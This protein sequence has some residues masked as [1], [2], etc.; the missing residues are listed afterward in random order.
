MKMQQA[1]QQMQ[2][3]SSSQIVTATALNSR[4]VPMSHGGPMAVG[5]TPPYGAPPV[6]IVFLSPRYDAWVC[7]F[8]DQAAKDKAIQSMSAMSSAQIVSASA[9][10]NKAVASGL[11][12][13][14][15]GAAAAMGP[16]VRPP[17]GAPTVSFTFS[18][19]HRRRRRQISNTQ[20][21]TTTARRRR[22]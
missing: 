2:S 4:G 11:A 16:A 3:M 1:L 5:L 20:T 13:L 15:P 19:H 10:H 7:L 22:R 17:Y 18:S 8:Q 9:I 14:T 21:T 12:G 6:S